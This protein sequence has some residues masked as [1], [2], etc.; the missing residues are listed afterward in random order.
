MRQRTAYIALKALWLPVSHLYMQL[1]WSHF[2]VRT[3]SHFMQLFWSHFMQFI[4]FAAGVP[5]IVAR[6]VV[7]IA[8]F[9]WAR[10]GRRKTFRKLLKK[11]RAMT[12]ES[13]LVDPQ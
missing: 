4:W 3:S 11:R 9:I 13:E 7:I 8:S 6:R 1:I 5:A 2:V 10:E 12:H